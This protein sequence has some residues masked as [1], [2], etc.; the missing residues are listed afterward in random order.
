M[1]WDLCLSNYSNVEGVEV[2]REP[3]WDLCLSNYSNVE[4]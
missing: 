1:D 3:T 4:E 2:T